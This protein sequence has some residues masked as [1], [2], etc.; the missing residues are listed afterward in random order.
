MGNAKGV[1]VFLLVF[2]IHLAVFKIDFPN[3]GRINEI[4][5]LRCTPENPV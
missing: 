1:L 3:K 5:M 4:I 2:P